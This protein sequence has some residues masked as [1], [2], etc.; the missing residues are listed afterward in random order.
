VLKNEKS[1]LAW[2]RPATSQC[3]HT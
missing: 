3:R 2:Y 1:E